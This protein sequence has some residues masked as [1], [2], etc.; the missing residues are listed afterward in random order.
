MPIKFVKFKVLYLLIT[1]TSFMSPIT[2][3]TTAISKVNYLLRLCKRVSFLNGKRNKALVLKE[4]MPF[5][6]H[7]VSLINSLYYY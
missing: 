1:Y 4:M 7:S 2:L 6:F 3:F 5:Y